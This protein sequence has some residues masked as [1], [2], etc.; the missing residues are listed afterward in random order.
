L[1]RF[2]KKR[3]SWIAVVLAGILW[4]A[5]CGRDDAS[6]S[7]GEAARIVSLYPTATEILFALGAGERVVGRSSWCEYPP[8]A[9]DLPALGDAVSVSAES[10]IALRP[11][12]VLVASGSQEEAL[13]RLEGRTNVLRVAADGMHDVRVLIVDLARRTGRRDEGMK[14]VDAIDLALLAARNRA[15]TRERVRVVFVVQREPLV[16][17]GRGSYVDELLETV[18]AVNVA[19]D[20]PGQ[21]PALS[22]ESL[23][24]RAPEVILDGATTD[25]GDFWSRFPGRAVVRPVR[26]TVV[27]RPGPRL[28]EALLVLER[29]VTGVPK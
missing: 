20:A 10:V 8:E 19:A 28:P 17:A 11:D 3:R 7:T 6:R 16:V 12:L 14:L 18:G 25:P 1:I 2:A 5:A 15:A 9:L 24:K 21:W 29:L 4:L 13:A 26:E 22:E 27:L 23:V